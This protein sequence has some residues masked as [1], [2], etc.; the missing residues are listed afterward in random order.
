MN[1]DGS[2]V[3]LIPNTGENDDV[4]DWQPLSEPLP[5]QAAWGDA[6]CRDGP[7]PID[8]LLTLRHDAGQGTETNECPEMGQEVDLVAASLHPVGR[9]GLQRD[10]RSHRRAEA[11][12][13]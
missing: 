12:S 10:G 8:G 2:N 13:I 4:P 7:N 5:L 11:A 9:R 1:P 6:S 3:T